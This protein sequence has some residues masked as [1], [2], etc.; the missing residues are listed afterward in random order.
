MHTIHVVIAFVLG[1]IVG[2]LGAYVY[3][4]VTK[5]LKV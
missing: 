1:V 3:L 2:G 4:A 5:K